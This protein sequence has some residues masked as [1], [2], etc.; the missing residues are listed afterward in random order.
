[1]IPKL[2]F[3]KDHDFSLSH[4]FLSANRITERV[5]ANHKAGVTCCS[6]SREGYNEEKVANHKADNTNTIVMH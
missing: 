1:M 5:T 2:V 3:S 4:A 6:Q